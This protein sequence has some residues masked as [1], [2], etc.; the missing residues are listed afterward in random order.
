MRVRTF[1]PSGAEFTIEAMV[2]GESRMFVVN[3]HRRWCDCGQFQAFRYPCSHAQAACMHIHMDPFMFAD[4][5]YNLHNIAN[6]YRNQFNT[7]P[8]KDYWPDDPI[9]EEWLPNPNL[10]W[11]LKGRPTSTRIHTNMD[12]ADQR[13]GGIQIKH[14]MLC[15]GPGHSQNKC[16]NRSHMYDK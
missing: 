15:R 9:N 7:I 10:R 6:I 14:C 4:P 11:K 13:E 3:L 8:N 12:D 2:R 1:D 16:P 5:C